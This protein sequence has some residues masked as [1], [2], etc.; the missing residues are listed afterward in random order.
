MRS[1]LNAHP[2]LPNNR[3]GLPARSCVLGLLL[4]AGAAVTEGTAAPAY[5]LLETWGGSGSAAGQFQRP[6]GIDAAD[7][8]VFVADTGNRR[9]QKLSPEGRP[10]AEFGT[11]ELRKPIDVAVGPDGTIYVSDFDLDRIVAFSAEGRLKF[12]WGESGSGPGAFEAPAGLTVDPEG[13]VYVAGFHDGRVQVFDA[14]GKLLRNIGGKGRGK[15]RF[16]YPTDVAVA[17]DVVLVADAY[18]HRLQ[19]L[20]REGKFIAAWGSRTARL[21]KRAGSF[22]VP[23]GVAVDGKG[24]VHVADSANKRLV[25]LDAEGRFLGDWRVQDDRRPKVY[26]PTRVAVLGDKVLAVDTA[27]DRILVLEVTLK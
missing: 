9:V 4:S 27:N 18:N 22:H 15:A 7:G 24:R 1:W 25:L 12:A 11:E 5:R 20:S 8:F 21:L 14:A 2:A 6:T 13:R 16:T 3:A 26:S 17:G 10:I 19:K 23:T